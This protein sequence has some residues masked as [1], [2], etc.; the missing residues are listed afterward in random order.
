MQAMEHCHNCTGSGDVA[1]HW[2]D[3]CAGSGVVPQS[4]DRPTCTAEKPAPKGKPTA[5]GN[6]RWD[7]N[8]L[9]PHAS[10]REINSDHGDV[11]GDC[12]HCGCYWI[13][14]GPDA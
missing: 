7:Y 8:W 12:P 4:D 1:G 9:H 14:E 13:W 5:A 3:I 10:E 11:R 2:C 6:H